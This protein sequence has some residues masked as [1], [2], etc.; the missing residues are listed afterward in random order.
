MKGDLGLGPMFHHRE[1]SIRAHVQFCW[2]PLL[3][4]RVVE[5]AA[6]DTWRNLRVELA[7]MHLVT[8]A[9]PDGQGAALRH[10]R[11]AETLLAALKL[12]KPR[13]SSTSRSRPKADLARPRARL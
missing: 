2:L 6:E 7:R 3:L 9:S 4:L 1:D 10:D 8:L 5:N 11:R 12:P 13:G